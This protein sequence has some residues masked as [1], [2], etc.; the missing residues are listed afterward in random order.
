MSRAVELER[1]Q[2]SPEVNVPL[3]KDLIAPLDSMPPVDFAFAYGSGVFPQRL[4]NR[5]TE[6]SEH[7]FGS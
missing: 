3:L 2:R 4:Q 1:D 5:A 6:V 7:S